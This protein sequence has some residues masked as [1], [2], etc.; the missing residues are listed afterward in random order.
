MLGALASSGYPPSSIYSLVHE[1]LTVKGCTVENSISDGMFIARASHHAALEDNTVVGSGNHGI[2]FGQDWAG[3]ANSDYGLIKN[4]TVTDSVEGGITVS[5]SQSTSVIGN[6]ITGTDPS[7]LGW[8]PWAIA[9]LSIMDGSGDID[10]FGNK[11]HDNTTAG[12]GIGTPG[13]SS[14]QADIL[15]GG[16]AANYNDVYNN[17]GGGMW[18]RNATATTG[19]VITYN[20]MYDNTGYDFDSLDQGGITSTI[21]ADARYNWWGENADPVVAG[22]LAFDTPGDTVLYSDWAG[23]PIPEP[24]TLCVLAMGALMGVSGRRRRG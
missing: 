21:V 17:A 3:V 6:E 19:I 7:T 10:V 24:A 13:G 18:F 22:H 12:I 1:Y 14:S 8:D 16:S 23:A 15:I 9:A 4:N 2:W 20:N 5:A 11:V